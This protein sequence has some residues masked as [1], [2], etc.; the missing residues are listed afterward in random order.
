MNCIQPF[1]QVLCVHYWNLKGGLDPEKTRNTNCKKKKIRIVSYYFLVFHQLL[2]M[3]NGCQL[4][5]E[6]FTLCVL[7]HAHTYPYPITPLFPGW[8]PSLS[9]LEPAPPAIVFIAGNSP[10]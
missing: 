3:R 1:V 7:P 4:E 9:L 5:I 8:G 10:Y 2:G 6:V